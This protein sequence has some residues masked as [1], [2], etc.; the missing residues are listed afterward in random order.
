MRQ[1]RD[2]G[3]DEEETAQSVKSVV[4]YPCRPWQSTVKLVKNFFACDIK[5]LKVMVD[6][7][8]GWKFSSRWRGRCANNEPG[9]C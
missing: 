8:C 1:G 5:A 4:S 9:R 3:E 6:N 7:G 2:V